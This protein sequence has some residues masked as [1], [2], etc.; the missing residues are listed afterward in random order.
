VDVKVQHGNA[1]VEVHI[2][3]TLNLKLIP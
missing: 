3:L 1:N 2:K